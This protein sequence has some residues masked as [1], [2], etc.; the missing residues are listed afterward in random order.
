MLDNLPIEL[1]YIIF[2]KLHNYEII[3]LLNVNKLFRKTIKTTFFLSYLLT[4]YHP[5][6]FNSEDRYCHMCNIHIYR[7]NDKN[8]RI[9][10]CNH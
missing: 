3:S 10:R 4:R 6:V 9:I 7:I 8:K 1:L 5:M 2:S